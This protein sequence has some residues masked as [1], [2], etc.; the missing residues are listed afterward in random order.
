MESLPAGEVALRLACDRLKDCALGIA[1]SFAECPC[2]APLTRLQDLK[3]RKTP[4]GK[5][6]SLNRIARHKI[7]M[8]S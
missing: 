6:A 1:V 4:E 3:V 2:V 7:S 8:L 5:N